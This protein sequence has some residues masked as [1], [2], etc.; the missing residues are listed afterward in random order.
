[1]GLNWASKECGARVIDCS[2]EI[3]G[4]EAK[5]VLDPHI[6]NI[7]LTEEGSPH[8]LCIALNGEN[9]GRKTTIRAIGWHCWHPYSTN[10]KEVSQEECSSRGMFP[11]D[12]LLSI[13][14]GLLIA[15]T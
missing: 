11:K 2:S 5:N 7:W 4:C 14:Y 12:C 6:S 1:M 13:T 8:W 10:P 15:F 9:T 3:N